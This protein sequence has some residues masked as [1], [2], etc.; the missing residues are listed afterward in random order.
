MVLLNKKET[1]NQKVLRVR[2]FALFSVVGGNKFLK[3]RITPSSEK[4]ICIFLSF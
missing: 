2:L 3:A 1:E 4:F